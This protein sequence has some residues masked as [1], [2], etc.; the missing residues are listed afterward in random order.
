MSELAADRVSAVEQYARVSP[1]SELCFEERGRRSDPPVLLIM[2]LGLDLCWWRDAFYDRLAGRGFRAVRFDNRDIGR[3]TRFSGSGVSSL[4]FLR[5]TATPAYTLG[6]MA[7]DAASLIAHLA[8]GGQAHVVGA[9]MGACIAQEVAIRHPDRVSSLV[10]IMGRPGDKR[11]GRMAKRM[12]PQFMRVTPADPGRKLEALVK[13]FRRIGSVGR[14]AEDDEDV[15][16][17]MR[18]S[19]A[20]EQG[21]GTG[22]GRQLAAILAERDRTPDLRGLE[23]PTTVIHGLHDRVILLFRRASHRRRDPQLTS[24]RSRG[25]GTT[26][27]GGCG[28][29]CSARSSATRRGRGEAPG[30]VGAPPLFA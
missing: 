24:S 12:L 15:R 27:R 29:W 19:M 25:W 30:P 28:R 10:S 8:P 9:S 16:T 4:Q 1:V 3:S 5:R 6:D 13:N 26:C 18:R 7:D 17:A 2:G 14:T 20:R 23:I 22:P 11:T 21:D